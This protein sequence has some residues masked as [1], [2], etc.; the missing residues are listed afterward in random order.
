MNWK[1]VSSYSKSE[2]KT[3]KSW[4]LRAGAFRIVVTRHIHHESN[5]W[6]FFCEPFRSVN[7][8]AVSIEAAKQEAVAIVDSHLRKALKE[9]P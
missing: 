8:G 3:P 4:E 1:D 9:L 7:L 6:V 2:T 5:E